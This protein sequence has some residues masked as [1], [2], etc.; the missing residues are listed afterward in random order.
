MG[1]FADLVEQHIEEEIQRRL[2]DYVAKLAVHFFTTEREIYKVVQS[3]PPKVKQCQG[4]SKAGK[5]CKNNGKYDGYCHL[6]KR[7]REPKQVRRVQINEQI[8][9]SPA[10]IDEIF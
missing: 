8:R 7:E 10:V 6:H 3:G 5:A 9:D 4:R 2:A 1:A